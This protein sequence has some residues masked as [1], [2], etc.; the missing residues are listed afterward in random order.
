MG[1]RRTR[2]TDLQ[3]SSLQRCIETAAE[4]RDELFSQSPHPQ[5]RGLKL[6]IADQVAEEVLIYAESQGL[7]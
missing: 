7:R 6:G 3:R 5:E 2:M 4:Y 1:G